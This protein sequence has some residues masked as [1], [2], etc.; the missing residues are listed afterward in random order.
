VCA[1]LFHSVDHQTS[2]LLALNHIV[3]RVPIGLYDSELEFV[4]F[5]FEVTNPTRLDPSNFT[6][7]C[8]ILSKVVCTAPLD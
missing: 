7:M 6:R 3:S 2:V 8:R 5:L 1:F 4:S